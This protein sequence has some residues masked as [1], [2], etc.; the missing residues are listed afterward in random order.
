MASSRGILN[1]LIQSLNELTSENSEYRIFIRKSQNLAR[2]RVYRIATII[3]AI[4]DAIPKRKTAE[5]P[6][7][8]STQTTRSSELYMFIVLAKY[9]HN[10]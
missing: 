2:R 1:I 7:F 8:H 9:S 6:H 5:L 4:Y 3:V 10:L